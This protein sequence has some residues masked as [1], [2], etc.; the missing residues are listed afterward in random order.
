[1][2]RTKPEHTSRQGV[3]QMDLKKPLQMHSPECWGL[4]L[5]CL[6]HKRACGENIEQYEAIRRLLK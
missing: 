1:M 3:A 6:R 4:Q 2:E 5:S